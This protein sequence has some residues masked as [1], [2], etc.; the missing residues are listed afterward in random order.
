MTSSPSS[1][2]VAL[3]QMWP[4]PL[5]A[6]GNFGFAAEQIRIAAAQGAAL[7]VIPEYHL[8]GWVPE[9][10][11]FALSPAESTR[12]VQQYQ[13][14]AS[15]LRINICA[16]TIVSHAPGGTDGEP[17]RLLNTS[18]FID[19]DG[20][21]L[22][23]YCKTNLW[24]PEREHLTSSIVYANGGDRTA[25][26]TKSSSDATFQ[27]HQVFDTPLGPVGILVC[28]DIA[29]PEAF[30]QLV[31]AGAKLIIIPSFW[32]L[33]D[34]NETGLRHNPDCERLF[35]ESTL[36]TRAFE[37]TAALIFT[38]AGGPADQGFFGC[39]QVTMPIVGKV[40]GSFTD[41]SEGTRVLDVDMDLVEIAEQN[42][43]IRQDLARDDW[44]YGYAGAREATR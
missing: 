20:Q 41:G 18:Y 36:V 31:L 43:R 12:Y 44:H 17:P 26:A 23:S 33:Q 35:V 16:G 1:F 37:S 42:Y 6:E 8:T 4:K 40:P 3:I 21:I 9:D 24:I 29:F 28:W 13:Q 22:G 2:K 32:T 15:S 25:T 10:P 34:M 7:A 19:H 11:T 39:S 14:L 5:D 30:R 38:N 27:P